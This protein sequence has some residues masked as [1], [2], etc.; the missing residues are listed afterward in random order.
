M[1]ATAFLKNWWFAKVGV[2]SKKV[3]L[4]ST[5]KTLLSRKGLSDNKFLYQENVQDKKKKGI[6]AFQTKGQKSRSI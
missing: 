6:L 1:T 4:T 3:H 2:V 5:I